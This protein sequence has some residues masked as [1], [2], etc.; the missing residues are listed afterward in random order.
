MSSRTG[1]QIRERWLNQLDPSIH[2][3][4]WE[5]EEDAQLLGA[6][7]QLG[8]KWVQVAKLLPGR[9]ENSVKNRWHSIQNLAK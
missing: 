8:P 7:D 4:S 6:V 2:K 3:G 5:A 9:T 1:K